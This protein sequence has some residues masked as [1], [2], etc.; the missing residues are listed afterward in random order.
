MKKRYISLILAVIMCMSLY[1]P[2]SAT[3]VVEPDSSRFRY[4]T[5]TDPDWTYSGQSTV[6]AEESKD[7][8]FMEELLWDG[9]S[10]AAG[11]VPGASEIT[12]AVAEII[13]ANNFDCA[14]PGTYTF[15]YKNKI[16]Y[17]EHLGTGNVYV[18]LEQRIIRIDF[19]CEEKS[20]SRQV[21]V[22]IR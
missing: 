7:Y 6:T 18:E 9:L 4:Y 2:A 10:D 21:T 5:V 20:N 12:D 19:K 17:K 22:T 8:L 13:R 3:D 14:D 15:Y 1:V 11:A 16:R